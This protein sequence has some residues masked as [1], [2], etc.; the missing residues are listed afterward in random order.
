MKCM[1]C[2]ALLLIM[3]APVGAQTRSPE[4]V[5]GWWQA[6]E[7]NHQ[8]QIMNLFADGRVRIDF[9]R[10]E[11]CSKPDRTRGVTLHGRCA[12]YRETQ[13]GTWHV[14]GDSLCVALSPGLSQVESFCK[15]YVLVPEASG[16]SATL[17]LG[18]FDKWWRID[19]VPPVRPHRA[20]FTAD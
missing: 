5:G 4:L 17:S 19:S 18:R 14:L 16:G 1:R 10:E 11:A 13:R 15:P 2:A 8:R 3:A 6:D 20:S 9:V 12:S 7:Y